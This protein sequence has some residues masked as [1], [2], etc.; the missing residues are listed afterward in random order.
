[1]LKPGILSQQTFQ[2]GGCHLGFMV[3]Q[4]LYVGTLLRRQRDS[5]PPS[6]STMIVTTPSE[7]SS[8]LIDP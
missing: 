5:L 6:G 7:G 3:E 1:L 4:P 8:E 2:N